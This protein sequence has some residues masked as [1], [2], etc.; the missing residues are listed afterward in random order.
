MPMPISQTG[1]NNLSYGAR[2]DRG[3]DRAANV[4][5]E[6][7]YHRDQNAAAASIEKPGNHDLNAK[8]KI[9]ASYQ[10]ICP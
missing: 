5:G 6:M 9:R 2:K 1:R 8:E 10:G 7:E 4:R 3:H